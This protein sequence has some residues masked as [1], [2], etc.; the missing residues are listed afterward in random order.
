MCENIPA[1]HFWYAGMLHVLLF[2]LPTIIW[3]TLPQRFQFSTFLVIS[4]AEKFIRRCNCW[5]IP[6][7]FDFSPGNSCRVSS[8][9]F[10]YSRHHC[11]DFTGNLKVICYIDKWLCFCNFLIIAFSDFFLA[12]SF[13]FTFAL[14]LFPRFTRKSCFID[15]IEYRNQD[16]S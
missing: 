1:Y 9:L 16:F 14:S 12:T 3:P 11:P 7:C 15:A 8:T 5:I 13:F 10:L 2:A 6:I 4:F